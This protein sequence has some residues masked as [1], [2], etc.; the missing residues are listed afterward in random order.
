MRHKLGQPDHKIS[1]FFP[2]SP[3]LLDKKDTALFLTHIKNSNFYKALVG[4]FAQIYAYVCEG[5]RYA[6]LPGANRVKNTVR[7]RGTD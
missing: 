7:V 3:A 4:I 1:V 5:G 2:P 6:L